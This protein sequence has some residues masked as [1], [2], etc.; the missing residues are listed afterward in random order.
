MANTNAVL[1]P[2]ALAGGVIVVSHAVKAELPTIREVAGV[3]GVGF[4][5]SLVALSMPGVGEGL[6]WLLFAGVFL[7]HGQVV[8]AAVNTGTQSPRKA[9]KIPTR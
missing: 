1:I 2:V 9:R 3:V 7:A 5:A 6:A 8:V 4:A